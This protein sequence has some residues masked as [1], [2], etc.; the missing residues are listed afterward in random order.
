MRP[1][2]LPPAH[3]AEPELPVPVHHGELV[4]R[5]EFTKM[6]RLSLFAQHSL[7]QQ[8]P[9]LDDLDCV[10]TAGGTDNLQRAIH[11]LVPL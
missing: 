8:L 5:V 10:G 9:V 1:D 6:D 4:I 7:P 2:N 3:I 11:V